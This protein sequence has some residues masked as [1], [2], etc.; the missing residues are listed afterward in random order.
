MVR[1]PGGAPPPNRHHIAVCTA[2]HHNRAQ[3]DA[4]PAPDGAVHTDIVGGDATG[5]NILVDENDSAWIIDFRG[6]YT[7]G[8]SRKRPG[9]GR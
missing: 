6:S 3:A 7:L 8:G 2:G 4:N 5:D 9:P 1:P